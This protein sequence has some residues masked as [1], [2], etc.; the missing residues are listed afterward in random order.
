MRLNK[1]QKEI[2]ITMIKGLNDAA[3]YLVETYGIDIVEARQRLWG[4][5][6]FFPRL[7]LCESNM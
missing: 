7:E 3:K 1:E 2:L 6:D 5:G 4:N